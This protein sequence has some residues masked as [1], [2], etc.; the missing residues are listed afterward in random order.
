[1]Q[2]HT[3]TSLDR[4][5]GPAPFLQLR[6]NGGLEFLVVRLV[7]SGVRWIESGKRLRNVLGDR[8]GDDRVNREVRVAKRM[9]VTRGARDVRRYVHETNSLGSLHASRFADLDLRVPRVLKEWRQPAEL[10]LRAAVDQDI[11]IAH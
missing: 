9:H 5:I 10:K 3:H 11:S 6:V 2:S 8:F 4:N 7:E 1:M